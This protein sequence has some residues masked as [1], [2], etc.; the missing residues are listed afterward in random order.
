MY[1]AFAMPMDCTIPVS[2]DNATAATAATAIAA[3]APSFVFASSVN[4][5]FPSYPGSPPQVND[6][7]VATLLLFALVLLP[8]VAVYLMKKLLIVG[9]AVMFSAILS[10]IAAIVTAVSVFAVVVIGTAATVTFVHG[11]MQ[12]DTH[13][14][15]ACKEFLDKA[16]SGGINVVKGTP[17]TRR[18]GRGFGP[19]L[20]QPLRR[21]PRL[22]AK[23]Q[24]QLTLTLTVVKQ[25]VN[26]KGQ[27]ALRRKN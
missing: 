2:F 16:Q 20:H 8:P 23:S 1:S 27:R 9:L 13:T 10:V 7:L 21:S 19:F 18:T 17:A 12:T 15:F 26:N 5:T 6:L 4:T 14:L 25:P 22:A 3:T 11:C 24:P